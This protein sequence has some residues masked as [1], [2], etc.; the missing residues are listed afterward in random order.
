MVLYQ[1]EAL[2][3]Q[4]TCKE[5]GTNLCV[6]PSTVSKMVSKKK[7]VAAQRKRRNTESSCLYTI[8]EETI[9]ERDDAK[10][11]SGDESI[12]CQGDCNGWLHRRC[13]GL[14]TATFAQ[15]SATKDDTSFFCPSCWASRLE[16]T[17]RKLQDEISSCKST[18]VMV[19]SELAS[20]RSVH[21]ATA[22]RAESSLMLGLL[23]GEIRVLLMHEKFEKSHQTPIQEKISRS[24]DLIW[25]YLE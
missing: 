12:F 19:Q 2:D 6:D 15:L 3:L 9:L 23:L 4:L 1:H 20:L 11:I 17:V 21:G 8:C 24:I 13:A 7:L 18:L 10:N 22:P 5:V 16:A 25:S 14:N